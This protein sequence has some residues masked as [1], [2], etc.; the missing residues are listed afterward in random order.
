MYKLYVCTYYF[1]YETL[2]TFYIPQSLK[3]S[4]AKNFLRIYWVIINGIKY[5]NIHACKKMV[6]NIDYCHI[7]PYVHV[8]AI[9]DI[10]EI[11]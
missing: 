9:S 11:S 5:V 4:K 10:C 3:V 2:Y 1:I 6:K 7:H 8:R